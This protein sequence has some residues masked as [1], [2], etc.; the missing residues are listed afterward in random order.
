M[1]G[2]EKEELIDIW[3]D[4]TDASGPKQPPPPIPD[5]RELPGRIDEVDEDFRRRIKLSPPRR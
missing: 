1:V 2:Y 5:R 3:E 4:F